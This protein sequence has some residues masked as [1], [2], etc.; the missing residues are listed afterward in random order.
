MVFIEAAPLSKKFE[1]LCWHRTIMNE[2]TLLVLHINLS[3]VMAGEDASIYLRMSREKTMA[4]LKAKIAKQI[5]IEPTEFTVKRQY[6]GSSL[7][8]PT[9]TLA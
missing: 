1:E 9:R 3:Q 8:Y 4:D 7:N 5:C 6:V 2:S